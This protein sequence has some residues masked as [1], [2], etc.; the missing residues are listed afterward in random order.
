MTLVRLCNRLS[1]V[2]LG[3]LVLVA[4]HVEAAPLPQQAQQALAPTYRIFA[5]REGLVGEMTGNGHI[6]QPRDRFVALPSW[7][8]LSPK[9]SDRYRVRVT[10]KGRSVVVPVW[11]VGPWNTRDDYWTPDRLYR[12]L[13]VGRPMAEAAFFDGYNGGLDERGRRINNPNGIDI[14]DGTFWDD[15]LMTRNDWVEV[16]FLWLGADPGP[17]AA[18]TINPPPPSAPPAPPPAPTSV[19]APPVE[20]EA[21]SSVVDDEAEG[22]RAQGS[23]WNNASCGM[24][25]SHAWIAS[26]SDATRSTAAA[27]WTPSL[28]SAGSYEVLAY[29][30]NCGNPATTSARYQVTHDDAVTSVTINQQALAG[31]WVSLGTYSF[32]RVVGVQPQVALTDLTDENGRTVRFDAL[33]WAPRLDT[34]PPV[35]SIE[36]IE[37]K[38]NGYQITWGGTDDASSIA[39]YD[40]QVRILP[41]GGWTDWRMQTTATTAWFGPDEGKHFAFRVRARDRAG[42]L[43]PWPDEAQMDT[44]SS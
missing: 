3:L 25:G 28:P 12:D 22:Y 4:A 29:L 39:S 35:S 2:L 20:A 31:T 11:D 5:T 1:V 10:Y 14:A 38:G 7:A 42:N 36:L 16:S 43:E 19:P 6:I 37:R 17:G 40:V 18:I 21:G 8:V 26:T 30:P 44:T 32:G 34:A 15:L 9:G 13:P 23:G 41:R 27:A 33:A 24:N